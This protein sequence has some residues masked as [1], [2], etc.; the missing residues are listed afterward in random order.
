MGLYPTELEKAYDKKNKQRLIKLKVNL[1][2]NCGACSYVCPAR[3]DLA[4]KH[5]LAKALILE[6]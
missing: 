3:R 4:A 1:C 2:M 5:Q 6:K